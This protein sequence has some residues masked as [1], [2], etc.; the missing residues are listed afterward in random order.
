M[1]RVHKRCIIVHLNDSTV[2][3]EKESEGASFSPRMAMGEGLKGC[4]S[5]CSLIHTRTVGVSIRPFATV[6]V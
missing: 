1:K 2:L 3:G 5:I 4:S 6:I